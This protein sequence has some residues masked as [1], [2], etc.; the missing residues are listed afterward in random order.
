M[1]RGEIRDRFGIEGNGCT[2][3]LVSCFCQP[4]SLAQMNMELKERA[5]TGGMPPAAQGYVQQQ[6][7]GMDYKP[8]P[9]GY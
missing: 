7:P 8:P 6:Q 2:D 5:A 1:K 9:Q 4:C 3:C